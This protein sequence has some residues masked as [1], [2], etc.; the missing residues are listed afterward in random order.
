[1]KNVLKAIAILFIF[2]G[3][4]Y[5]MEA[6]RGPI[7]H[8]L[9]EPKKTNWQA[10]YEYFEDGILLVDEGYIHS[11]GN[12]EDVFSKIPEGTE[13]KTFG[14]NQLLIPGFV[15][16]HIHFPQMGMI[17]SYGEQLLEWLEKYT[18][19][20]EQR[21]SEKEY[22]KKMANLFIKEL[23][24]NGTTTALVFCTAAEESVDA[25]F[26]SAEPYRMRLIAG[27]TLGDRNMPEALFT[28]VESIEAIEEK[29]IQRWHQKDRFLYAVTPRFAPTSSEALLEE[30]GKILDKRPDLYLHTHLSEN[31]DEISWVASLFPWSRNYLDVYHRYGLV[32]PRS[33]FAHAVHISDQEAD[34]LV[35]CDASVC[36]CPTSNLFLGSGLFRW[37]HWKELGL[38]MA[39]GTDVGAGTSF[40]LLSTMNE[41]YKIAQLQKNSMHPLEAFYQATLGGAKALYLDSKIGNFEPGKEADFVVLNLHS[42]ELMSQRMEETSDIFDRLFLLMMLGDERNIQETY[43]MGCQVHM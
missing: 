2:K 14:K 19:P 16:A 35:E 36:H 24:K 39:F 29:L 27:R 4:L 21:F 43:V 6:Y 18:F 33:V 13:I 40:S 26:E 8:F 7:L 10:S 32:R 30:V 38:R 42:T 17:G 9:S 34:L 31:K 1:M 23:L 3:D 22:A 37:K 11:V 5:S 25:L 15:D 28:P 12:A 41:G 20:F